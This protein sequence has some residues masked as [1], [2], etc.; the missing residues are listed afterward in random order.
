VSGRPR[1]LW[2]AWRSRR[3]AGP[4]SRLQPNPDSL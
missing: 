3:P 1:K 2:R 4:G